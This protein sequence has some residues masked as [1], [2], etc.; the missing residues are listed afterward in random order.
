[1][2]LDWMAKRVHQIAEVALNL[3]AAVQV[4]RELAWL[5]IEHLLQASLTDQVTVVWFGKR[6]ACGKDC[7]EARPWHLLESPNVVD[8]VA[9][10]LHNLLWPRESGL[11]APQRVEERSEPPPVGREAVALITGNLLGRQKLWRTANGVRPIGLLEQLPRT[12]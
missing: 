8:N 7:G 4:E 3:F 1:M 6:G 10:V 9:R 2:R 11:A 5:V 12:G